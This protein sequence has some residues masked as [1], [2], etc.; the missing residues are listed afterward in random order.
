MGDDKGVVT[1]KLLQ[2][3][4][5]FWPTISA[6]VK[7]QEFET[8]AGRRVLL[9]KVT[10]SDPDQ[11]V[12]VAGY[13]HNGQA[14]LWLLLG[15]TKNHADNE[16]RLAAVLA[17]V[18]MAKG[19]EKTTTVRARLKNPRDIQQLLACAR[20]L[21]LL[22]EYRE[23]ALELSSLRAELAHL[24]PKTVSNGKAAHHPSYGLTLKNP[25][26]PSNG[27][28]RPNSKGSCP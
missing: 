14:Y 21:A 15:S 3:Q 24:L 22:G 19:N 5:D 17:T 4:R 20:S 27:S 11:D 6:P 2:T 7:K 26:T 18:K 1:E 12:Q 28:R 8:I 25:P 23:A 10:P 16:E 9:L 13:N